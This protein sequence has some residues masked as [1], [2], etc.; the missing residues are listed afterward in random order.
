MKETKKA[1][2]RAYAAL[3]VAAV[4][5]FGAAS[6]VFAIGLGDATPVPVFMTF[7]AIWATCMTA[8]GVLPGRWK[9]AARLASTFAVGMFLL[10]LAGLLG[11][12]NLQIEGF[13][14][15]AFAGAMGRRS[16][17]SGWRRSSGRLRRGGA[18]AGGD[19][20]RGLR[21][22]AC[23]TGGTWHGSRGWGG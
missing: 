3:P 12:H 17:I 14:F 8:Y 21:L 11:R 1:G 9:R 15:H 7:A 18:G 19:A 22:I 4:A 2:L 13:F 23:P 20:G 10:V 16:C 6:L 5:L